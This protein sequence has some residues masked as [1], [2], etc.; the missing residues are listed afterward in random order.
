MRN[1]SQRT[2][3]AGF[4]L[5]ELMITVVIA[6]VLITIA[7]PAYNGEIRK[8]RRTDAKTALLDLAGREERFYNTN[9]TYSSLPSDLGYNATARAFPMPV[10]NGYYTVNVVVTPAAGIVGPTYTITAV[11][12]TAD[13]LNDTQCLL[14][15]LTNTGAQTATNASC[16]Q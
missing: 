8:S 14:F 6:T 7:I 16:W 13:Q 2:S 10:G 3:S 5:I 9:N 15:T 11:P 12:L 4:T 1:T